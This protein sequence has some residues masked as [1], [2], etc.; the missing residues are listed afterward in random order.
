MPADSLFVDNLSSETL[1]FRLKIA[2]PV[3]VML[4]VVGCA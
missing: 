3:H 4:T 2:R 1:S